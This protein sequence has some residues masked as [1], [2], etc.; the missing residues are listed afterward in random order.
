MIDTP[1]LNPCKN[2]KELVTEQNMIKKY[3][4]CLDVFD[5]ADKVRPVV[6]SVE[7]VDKLF[8]FIKRETT[9]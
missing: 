6:L 3:E 1:Y 8:L 5:I 9:I 4:V 7:G 2:D